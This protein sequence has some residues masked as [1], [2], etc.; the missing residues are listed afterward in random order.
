MVSSSQIICFTLYFVSH[1]SIPAKITPFH[2]ATSSTA[3]LGNV[4]SLIEETRHAVAN[5][6]GTL[7][8]RAKTDK[9]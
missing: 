4:V 7:H 3:L 8:I 5:L 6:C 9:G 1:G 2:A